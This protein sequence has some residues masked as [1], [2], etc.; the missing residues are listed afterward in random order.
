[1]MFGR[2]ALELPSALATQNVECL[3]TSSQAAQ[4]PTSPPTGALIGVVE[5]P[6]ARLLPDPRGAKRRLAVDGH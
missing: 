1:M 5:H 2:R 6:T 4:H 3:L